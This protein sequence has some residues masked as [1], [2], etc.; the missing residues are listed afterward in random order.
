MEGVHATWLDAA[1]SHA[2]SSADKSRERLAVGSHELTALA[3]VGLWRVEVEDE[4]LILREKLEAVGG[5][6]VRY[7]YGS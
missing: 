4:L 3:G 2:G 7:E 5:T 1:N 6:G